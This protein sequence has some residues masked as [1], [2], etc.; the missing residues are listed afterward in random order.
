MVIAKVR[1]LD[2]IDTRVKAHRVVVGDNISICPGGARAFS[3]ASSNARGP[4]DSTTQPER[5]CA[6]GP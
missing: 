4:W 2:L 1:V 5:K 6:G 3:R